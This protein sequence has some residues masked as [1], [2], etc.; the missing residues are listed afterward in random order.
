MLSIIFPSLVLF[1]V[2]LMFSIPAA[3]SAEVHHD[4]F[5][6]DFAILHPASG[7]TMH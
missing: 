4:G 2:Y 7:V 5:D 6:S 3:V 1:E